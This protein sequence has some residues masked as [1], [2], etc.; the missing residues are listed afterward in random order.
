M[1]SDSDDSSSASSS[2][3]LKLTPHFGGAHITP[4]KGIGVF[5]DKAGQPSTTPTVFVHFL[6]KFLAASDVIVF[7]HLRPLSTPTVPPEERYAVTR[8][9]KS[10]PGSA[11]SSPMP[12]CFRLV[13]RHGYTNEVITRDLG[14]LVCEQI[15]NFL[16]REGATRAQK[17]AA[18]IETR[19]KEDSPSSP[20]TSIDPNS[21]LVPYTAESELVSSH[22]RNLQ[23]VFEQQ[24]VYIVGKE[25]MRIK[26]G[27]NY[28]RRVV[29]G[30]FMDE[31]EYEE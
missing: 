21:K 31:G 1:P 30:V 28:L 11:F 22:L 20:H 23:N 2:R 14:L 29:M 24:V 4:I 19:Q 27:T 13:I 8:C 10:E 16:I 9:F 18:A 7:F 26:D 17:P 15:R 6:Q 5:F 25:Q 3:G 12:S